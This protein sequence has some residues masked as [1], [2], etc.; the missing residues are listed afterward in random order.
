V[1]ITGTGF[2]DVTSVAFGGVESTNV[3]VLLPT[4]IQATAPAPEGDGS[5]VV[6]VTVSISSGTSP[7][8]SA[9]Q[10]QYLTGFT[11]V[12]VMMTLAALAASAATE[13]PSGETA[14]QQAERILAGINTQ[15]ANAA[16]ATAGDWQALWV[17][18]TQDRA[19]LVYIAQ[20][21]ASGTPQLAVCLRGTVMGSAIDTAEDMDV[22][23]LLEFD[24]AGTPPSPVSISQG[25]MEAFTGITMGTTLLQTLT[26]VVAAQ[27]AAPTIFVCGHSLGGAL[28]TTVSLYLKTQTFIPAPSFQVYTFAA[29]TAG[30]GAFA[31]WFDTQFPPG[32]AATCV[33]NQYDAVPN[34]WWNLTGDQSQNP[35][36][37][38]YFYPGM[39]TGGMGSAPW[40]L[41]KTIEG[42]VTNLAA[43][44]PASTYTQ[45]TQQP[46]LNQSFGCYS[47]APSEITSVGDWE[48]EVAYQHANNTYLGLLGAPPLPAVAPSVASVSPTG[49]PATGWT[50]VTITAAS[51]VVFTPDSVVDFGIVPA[52]LLGIAG[53]G[54]TITALSPAGV[55]TVDVRV[56]NQLGTSAVV[57]EDQFAYASPGS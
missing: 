4:E 12:Q 18:L 36:P 10:F 13:R 39:P 6:D 8:S 49:G 45:P 22:G 15:L 43:D 16:L 26:E 31:S 25:A 17:G 28:A 23:T 24:A 7:T 52:T 5:S 29:P 42:I 19:N 40:V 38:E 34:A 55:G 50:E 30:D 37:V 35:L 51:G 54:S 48:A 57:P 27:S 11:E 47:P 21:T 41:Q 9:D 53:D 33:W 32:T 56:T 44:A 2:S 1:T 20:N 3:Q 14:A 46:A